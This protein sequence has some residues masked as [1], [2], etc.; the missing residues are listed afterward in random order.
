[1]RTELPHLVADSAVSMDMLRPDC[2]MQH[3]GKRKW[4]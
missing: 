2:S 3:K 4:P 1:M